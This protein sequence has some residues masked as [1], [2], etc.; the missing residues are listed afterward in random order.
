MP[1]YIQNILKINI[2]RTEGQQSPSSIQDWGIF[3]CGVLLGF[4]VGWFV[5]LFACFPWKFLPKRNIFVHI[6]ATHLS[7]FECYLEYLHVAA[8][9]SLFFQMNLPWEKDRWGIRQM[10]FWQKSLH[11]YPMWELSP[12]ELFWKQTSQKAAFFFFFFFIL[13]LKGNVFS[14]TAP[15]GSCLEP[16]Q[17]NNLLNACWLRN[18]REGDISNVVA[19]VVLVLP[20]ATTWQKCQT[21]KCRMRTKQWRKRVK[22]NIIWWSWKR[23]KSP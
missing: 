15:T 7:S 11:C 13:P 18:F 21:L 2:F 3:G 20:R 10:A 12:T 4:F 6:I 16:W 22:I 1:W 5:C 19:V 14:D 8:H 9:V 17:S 23:N